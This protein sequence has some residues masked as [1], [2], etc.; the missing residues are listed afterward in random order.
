MQG[1][2]R[3][4][5]YSGDI[6]AAVVLAV[7]D[8]FCRAC[9]GAHSRRYIFSL[10]MQVKEGSNYEGILRKTAQADKKFYQTVLK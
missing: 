7:R 2:R 5:P 4:L 8:A 6:A 10:L 9:R 3:L 1:D